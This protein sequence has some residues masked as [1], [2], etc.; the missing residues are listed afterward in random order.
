M[1]TKNYIAI[2]LGA[3]SGRVIL[4]SVANG[5]ME[6]ETVKRFPTPLLEK[7]GKY[8]WDIEDI[9]GNIKLGLREVASRGIHVESIGVDTW[10]VDF[11]GVR[12][13]GHLSGMPRAYR[14]PYTNG[15]PE[16]FFGKMP[17]ET[18]YDKTGI[19]IMNFNSVFQLYAQKKEM[20]PAVEDG[21]TILFMPDAISYLLTGKKV[22]EYTIL[23]TAAIMDPKTKKIDTEILDVCGLNSGQFPEIVFPGYEIG[24]ITEE[25]AKETGLAGVMVKAV[26]GHD[27][28]SAVAAVPAINERFAYLSSGTWSLMGIETRDAIITSQMRKMNYTNEGGIG[29]TTRVLKNI[30]GMWILENVIS[31]WKKQGRHYSYQEMEQMARSCAA[32]TDLIDP[33]APEFASPVDMPNAIIQWMEERH[34]QTPGSDAAMIRLIYDSLAAKYASVLDKLRSVAP[35]TI[36]VLH[37]IGGG[38]QNRL[39]NQLTAN[40]CGIKVVAGPSE[41][42]AVGN[43]MVQAGLTREQVL[44]SIETEI[45]TPQN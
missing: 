34:L 20:A 21:N 2:D 9:F 3:T 13:D 15:I 43:I 22:C 30:T 4:A 12:P 6:M 19:Q 18:L 14:D 42:T 33:D 36:D 37:I 32:S 29:G 39:L 38:S 25:V 7:N 24:T 44:A 11:A 31:A 35:F 28:G 45:F 16:E 23:S 17:L 27:T 1:E 10:G 8:Y 41:C 26:A 5:R 40:A